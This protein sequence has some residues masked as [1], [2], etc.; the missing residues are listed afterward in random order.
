MAFS[1]LEFEYAMTISEKITNV[2]RH[3]DLVL[4]FWRE[5]KKFFWVDYC[6]SNGWH[7]LWWVNHCLNLCGSESSITIL[8]LSLWSKIIFIRPFRLVVLH[9]GFYFWSILN[10]IL[11]DNQIKSQAQIYSL[12]RIGF[13]SYKV[14]YNKELFGGI[15]IMMMF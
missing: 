4:E 7:A 8:S 11:V 15:T 3:F 5:K 2:W 14:K 6:K 9:F 1:A 12:P 13:F 10:D